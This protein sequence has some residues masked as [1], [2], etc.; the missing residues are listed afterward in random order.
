M[1]PVRFL[2]LAL[3]ATVSLA[4]LASA[5]GN[6]A[7]DRRFAKIDLN[8]SASVDRT[9]FLALQPRGK[10]WVDAT[11]RFNV[12]D[13]DGDELLSQTEFRASNGGKEGGKPSKAQS[14]AL[15]DLDLDGF[16]S[17]EEFAR[18]MA[19]SKPWRKVLRDFGRKDRDDDSLLSPR[20]FGVLPKNP[21]VIPLR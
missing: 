5:A 1:H 12:A 13:V 18:T 21:L 17:P 14:F 4:P 10:S 16:L 6:G 19:Q 3:F 11:H 2:S 20:E 9:E 15:A 8:S 7:L